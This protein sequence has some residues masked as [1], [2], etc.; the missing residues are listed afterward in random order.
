MNLE[1]MHIYVCRWCGT[2]KRASEVRFSQWNDD[3]VICK[4]CLDRLKQ[5]KEIGYER[6][7]KEI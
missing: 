1:A 2:P 4:E 6:G 3:E 7:I 5:E